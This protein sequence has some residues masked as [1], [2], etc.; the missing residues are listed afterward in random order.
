GCRLLARMDLLNSLNAKSQN[1]VPGGCE[2]RSKPVASVTATRLQRRDSGRVLNTRAS[3][4]MRSLES[5]MQSA[6]ASLAGHKDSGSESAGTA[7]TAVTAS[8]ADAVISL[9]AKLPYKCPV[10]TT[11]A[12]MPIT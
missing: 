8:L 9:P 6:Q 5:L 1:P 12:A 3:Q 10:S 7:D 11:T 4:D 2:S